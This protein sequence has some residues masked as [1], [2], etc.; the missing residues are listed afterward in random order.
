MIISVDETEAAGPE[1]VVGAAPTDVDSAFNAVIAIGE[2][3]I[4]G[5]VSTIEVN[6]LTPKLKKYI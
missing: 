3:F 4:G 5:E 6:I 2:D 1:A